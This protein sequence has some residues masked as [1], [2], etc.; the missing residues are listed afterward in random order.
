MV[1]VEVPAAGCWVLGDRHPELAGAWV[2][3][4]LG[5]PVGRLAE[6]EQAGEE[7]GAVVGEPAVGGPG[8]GGLADF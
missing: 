2:A 5:W 6:V 3:V 1:P 8:V 7:W 4:R